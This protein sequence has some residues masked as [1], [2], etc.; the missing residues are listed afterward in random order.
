LKTLLPL[1]LLVLLFSA[2]RKET[3]LFEKLPASRTGITFSNTLT[4]NDSI[5]VLK[6]EYVYNG[7][8][9]GVADFNGDGLQDVFFAGNQVSS[10]LYLNRGDLRFE[11]VTAAAGTETKLWCTGV[12]LVDVNQD[13]LTDIYLSTI[14]PDIRRAVPNLLF[15][16]E[17]PDQQGIPHFREVAR[18]V[19]LAD[20]SYA[21][22]AAWLDY[23]RDGDL[24]C[25]VLT[26]ALELFNRNLIAVSQGSGQERSLDRLYRNEGVRSQE[27]GVNSKPSALLTPDSSL[28]TPYFTDVSAQAGL[29]QRGWG[30]GVV[31]KDLTGDGWP[32]IYVANDF[33]SNDC[34]YVNQRN[35]T[36]RND[37]A[38]MLPHQS[39]NS[40][41]TDIADFNN[42]GAEDIVVVDMMPD[43][44]L[45]Q[46]TMFGNIAYD[47]YDMALRSGYQPQF[48][49]NVLQLNHGNGH[50]GDVG[51]LA[52]VNATDWSWSALFADFDN[53]GWR[54]LLITNGYG[55]DITDLDFISY[56]EE[57]SMFGS[58]GEERIRQFRKSTE[59]LTGVHKPDFLFRNNGDLTFT[60]KAADWGLG[61]ANYTNGAAY[62]DFDNDG[63]LD[64]VMNNLNE[65]AHVYRNRL[66]ERR[67][68]ERGEPGAAAHFLRLKLAGQ[69]GNREGLGAKVTLFFGKKRLYAEHA[70]QRG[71]KSTVENA[72]HF[73]LGA[74]GRV[75]SLDI[76]WPTGQ[77]QVLR[78][79][80]ANQTL[81]LRET[82]A[83][84][85]PRPVT[86]A[87]GL[88]ADV[89]HAV[90]AAFRD[91][92]NGYLDF[93]QQPTLPRLHSRS[94][95][96]LA[97][98]DVNGDGLDDFFAG[99]AAHQPGGLF[100]QQKDGTFRS[101]EPPGGA[102]TPE[103]LGVLL[104]DADG[105]GDLDLYAVGGSTEFGRESA[106]YQD[107][108]YLND[109]DGGLKS[110]ATAL[111]DTRAS[112]SCVTAADYD[113]DGDLDLFVGG[114]VAPGNYPLPARS[115]LLRNQSKEGRPGQFT[116]ATPP[117]LREVGMVTAA[118]WTDYDNDGWPDLLLAG[119]WMPLTF[120]KNEK[121][122]LHSPFSILNSQGWWN[123]LAAGDFDNDGDVDYVAGN[124]GLNSK[125]KASPDQ[126]VSVYAKDFDQN[127]TMDAILTHFIQ[128]K[129]YPTHPRGTLT[130]QVVAVKKLATTY[131][132][133]GRMTFS[134][135][136]KSGDLEGATVYHA[137]QMASAYVQNDGAGRFTLRPLP[138]LAQIAPMNGLAP[139]DFDHDGN[140]DLLAVG[141]DYSPEPLTGRYDAA[142]G[143]L[144]RGDGRGGFSPVPARESGLLV[145]GDAK[146][147]ALLPRPDGQPRFV[148]S[149]T[150]DS[151]QVWGLRK[152]LPTRLL[153]PAPDDAVALLHLA[154]GRTRRVELYRGSGYLSQSTRA[155]WLGPEVRRAVLVNGRGQR[156]VVPF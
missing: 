50:F 56:R 105:D 121:G 122:I 86:A 43:D 55:K 63:D 61:D 108:L 128:G 95:P 91:Q 25:F 130:D 49:R 46:K 135:L 23:D 74:A 8:G 12:S 59:N 154:N 35:G 150:S 87:P 92:Q 96:G 75:D 54:D 103:H 93:K 27:R 5:N 106:E 149:R 143:W 53:D 120:F 123:S 11:D 21:T 110:A 33:Q 83:T 88:L 67:E 26:N 116:D 45:R 155:V 113:H 119:E 94:G 31:V 141:N 79:V 107:A 66:N 14:A 64:L 124:L 68:A 111:P 99:G 48:V 80:P 13:G 17:G 136:F 112:G 98:G 60:N 84:R 28:L 115:Y 140:L 114:R 69:P 41:G 142:I 62:A 1:G 73:G 30:L 139:L 51:Y 70:L 148:V 102:K 76:A 36:F 90:G 39:H 37:I 151:L 52:G 125:Y 146:A 18:A 3:P 81:T 57:N 131:A 97:V 24:D 65:E 85:P 2:C 15:L 10:R 104:F 134:D 138:M 58:N 38:A 127:G 16:N 153:R 78:N 117:A 145:Q 6:F 126:P 133:Y 118:L 20:S 9:V 77:R 32:D 100:L 19:G 71:Y 34:L 137:T 47:S 101:A 40:M 22:Q 72:L 109:G 82:D 156:R 89:T 4:E 144:L 132:A 147:L 129:E 152:P 29:T 44:N 42:D 7:G